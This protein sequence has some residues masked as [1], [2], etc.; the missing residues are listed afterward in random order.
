MFVGIVP[1]NVYSIEWKHLGIAV[2]LGVY[3]VGSSA[4]GFATEDTDADICIVIS[5]Y[6]VSN[7]NNSSIPLSG[8]TFLFLDWSETWSR[9][10]SGDRP[11]SVAKEDLY[12][13][14][15]SPIMDRIRS[16]FLDALAAGG[17][18][19]IRARVPILRFTDYAT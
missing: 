3:L 11:T 7:E 5:S 17:C 14:F 4:N 9:E 18:D 15:S 16:S 8:M 13:V 1:S 19:L 6:P 10:V 12:V 2:D